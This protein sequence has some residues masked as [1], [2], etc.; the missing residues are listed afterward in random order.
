MNSSF[1]DKCLRHKFHSHKYQLTNSF[2]YNEE[3]DFFSITS[4]GYAQEVEVKISRSYFKADFKKY[5]HNSFSQVYGGQEY[6]VRRGYTAYK[7]WEPI[8]ESFVGEDGRGVLVEDKYG[9]KRP[10]RVPSGEFRSYISMMG[11]GHANKKRAEGIKVEA[12]S[13]SVKIFK[14]ILPNKFWFAVPD[15]LVSLD[16]V[17]KY[18]GL[19][20]ISED[21]V[22]TTAKRAPFIHK[23]K[24]NLN[25][26]L[27]DKFYYLSQ[28]LQN[29]IR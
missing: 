11:E 10:K 19:Y 21:G 26:V 23:K 5:K 16:E 2:V 25:Q 18:A 17:P 13:T 28:R 15:G 22:I 27:L 4:T 9:R 6:V 1:I 20:Y 24:H 8:M 14:P 7:I 12:M 29:K 3:S